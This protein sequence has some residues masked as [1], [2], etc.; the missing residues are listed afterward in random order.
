MAGDPRVATMLAQAFLELPSARWIAA[1][2]AERFTAIRGQFEILAEHAEDHG[3]IVTSGDLDGAVMWFDYTEPPPPVPDYDERMRAV[4]GAHYE[5]YM[6]LDRLMEHHH[7]TEP[8]VYV[9][10]VGV[11]EELRG[12][13]IA[14]AML[15][16]LH[17]RL[18]E[19]GT[20]AYLEAVSP[21]TAGLYQS[22]GYR[23]H[24]KPFHLEDGGPALYPMWRA[25]AR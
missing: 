16:G 21:R 2:P 4:C 8:H 24:A 1:D 14:S 7:P 12:K 20:P 15:R 19:E 6:H 18:D 22:V 17:D 11:R 23:A 9:A 25:P 10:L 3:G 5:R 13:G